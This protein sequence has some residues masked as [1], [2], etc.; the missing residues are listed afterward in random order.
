VKVVG[1]FVRFRAPLQIELKSFSEINF[2]V[3]LKL[4]LDCLDFYIQS[5]QG[6]L[7]LSFKF[8]K[9]IPLLS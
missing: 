9:V 5:L 2:M 1:V 6:D 3:V 4:N 7:L 8:F